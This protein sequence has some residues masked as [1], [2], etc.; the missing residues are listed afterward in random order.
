[1]I[2]IRDLI[3]CLQQLPPDAFCY[4]YEGEIC[5][6]VICDTS[7]EGTGIKKE[8]GYINAGELADI[9]EVKFIPS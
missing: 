6:I 4:A 7:N 9:E 8:L 1:M 2:K 3:V 5:G